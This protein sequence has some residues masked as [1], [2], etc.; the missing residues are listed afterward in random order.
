M[1]VSL[2]K[3]E[4]DIKAAFDAEKNKTENPDQSI[5]NI[6]KAIAVAVAEQIVQGINTAEVT[7]VPNLTAPSMGGPVTGSIDTTLKAT[8]E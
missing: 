6:A 4:E 5:A 8:A 2:S 3:L 7:N 1:A